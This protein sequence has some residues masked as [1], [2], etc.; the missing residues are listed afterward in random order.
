MPKP[1]SP[2]FAEVKIIR[3]SKE[4]FGI[5]IFHDAQGKECLAEVPFTM[6]GDEVR[7]QLFRK[8]GGVYQSRLEA[9]LKPAPER[10]PKK[11]AH[12]EK[13][14][15]CRWQHLSYETQ[16]VQKETTVRKAFE[17]LLTPEVAV[18]PILPCDPPWQYRNKMEFSFSS[19][20][21]G[22]N[23]LGL[24][25]SQS[26]GKVLNLEECH[27]VKPW[28]IEV[29]HAV[30]Q[31]WLENKLEAYHPMRNT[32]SLRTLIVREGITTGDRLVMLTVSGN[33]DYALKKHQLE[34]FKSSIQKAC[35][36]SNPDA[37]LSIFLRIQQIAKGSPTNFY[38]MQ[39]YGPD[40]I[41]ETLQV[42]DHPNEPPSPIHFRISPSAFFQPNTR[43]AEK[44]YSKAFQMADIASGSVVYDLYCGSGALG[45]CAARRARQVVG[46]E[47]SPEASLD[48]RTNAAANGFQ[49]ITILTGSVGTVLNQIKGNENFP[50]PDAIVI[51]PPRA[52]LDN[53][54]LNQV[55]RLNAHTIVYISCNPLTQ[56]V[57]IESLCQQGYQLKAIQPI[58]QF[59]QTIH[60]EN[61]AILK[62][63]LDF[64]KT[65]PAP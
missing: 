7:V 4:G 3:I 58:D 30:R 19:D 24:M 5:G 20:S 54:A 17:K 50:D 51:D 46:I 18:L 10:I 16:L 42:Q 47:I 21:L 59:P 12:F 32:G 11:C 56:A 33:P 27:L 13:C 39:L 35:E 28:F 31:W 65:S 8:R 36:Q 43:Q 6:P 55:L 2:R 44:I 64:H 34:S 23:Y 29:I 40:Y 26:R 52:G 45:L 38:E 15:G 14:G 53:E 41:R 9:H 25:L 22:H 37:T 1:K 48:A 49:N 62:K 63:R 61:I 60:I 57:N